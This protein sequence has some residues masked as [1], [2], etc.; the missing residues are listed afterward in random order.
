MRT[1]PAQRSGFRWWLGA[2]TG[3]SL[4][5]GVT[6]FAVAWVAAQ[7]GAATATVVLTAESIPLAVLILA[8]GVIADRWGIR[9]VMICCDAVMVAVMGFLAIVVYASGPGL[10]PV[11]ALVVVAL[12]AGT[13]S[14]L[15]RPAGGVF[16][17]LFA[18]GDALAKVMA[19]TT[20]F[21]Q[22]AM[23]AGPALGGVVLAAG[24]LTATSTLDA[25]SFVVV[26][27]V[28]LV[29]RPPYEP[30]TVGAGGGSV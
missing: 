2:A 5:D 20:V 10:V 4:G 7:H 16:P 30:P 17:R 6:F 21:K 12:A 15:R 9:R 1:A 14:A 3:S 19:T 24:G 13:A 23:T 29:V 25:A 11:W 27:V 28:L 8:G 22:L 18:R 26:L